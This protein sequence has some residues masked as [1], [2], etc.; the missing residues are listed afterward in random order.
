MS[1]TIVLF[2]GGLLVLAGITLCLSLV[3]VVT[4]E[5]RGVARSL[6]AIHAID[7]APDAL[8]GEL[9]RPFSERVIAPL[10]ERLVGI[11]RRIVR[12]GTHE[13]IQHRLDIAGNPP[14][15]DVNRIIGLKVLGLLVLGGLAFLWTLGGDSLLTHA[16]HSRCGGGLRLRATEHPALQRRAEAGDA[17]A[18][19]AP[20]RPRPA[21][22]LGRGRTGVRRG[23]H[24]GRQEHD[25]TPRPGVLPAPAGD[26]DR[27]RT[28]GGHARHGRANHARRP[29]VLLRGH[30]AGRSARH[31]DRPGP[32]DPEPRDAGQATSASR[33]EGSASAGEDHGPAGAVHPAVPV[34]RGHRARRRSGSWTA[35]SS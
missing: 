30:G 7:K 32:E 8:R 3:G 5:R 33:G 10:G 1:P 20:G 28:D 12:A 31:P 11:G 19:G 22:H 16:G 27:R 24:A 15:W 34:H 2:G 26:A 13:R 21:H 17:H 35:F 25:R 23:G 29:E 4:A 18:A 6:A 14:A 9:D